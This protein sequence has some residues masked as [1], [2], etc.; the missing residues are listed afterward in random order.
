MHI[1]IVDDDDLLRRSLRRTFERIGY[2]ANRG[3]RV[4]FAVDGN[5]CRSMVAENGPFDVIFMDGDLG[6][7]DTGPVVVLALREAG[8]RAT[9][10]MTSSSPDMSA[11]GVEAG[12]NGSCDKMA[13]GTDPEAILARLGIPPP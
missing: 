1:L 2:T 4:S 10:I 11:I 3:H 9:I 7:G 5:T 8:C 6:A 13:F 12:A